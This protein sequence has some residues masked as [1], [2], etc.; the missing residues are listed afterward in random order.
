MH[1]KRSG[2]RSSSRSTSVRS[3]D[4][5]CLRN[6]R[7]VSQE[8]FCTIQPD[9]INNIILNPSQNA[10]A[11]KV[12]QE[13]FCTIPP[14]KRKK[15]SSISHRMRQKRSEEIFWK[16]FYCC[17]SYP[18]QNASFQKLA[19]TT[20]SQEIFCTL[21]I[22][23]VL[24]SSISHRMH[25]PE[26]SPRRSSTPS[27]QTKGRR[28]TTTVTECVCQKSLPGDLLHHPAK[29]KQQQKQQQSQNASAKGLSNTGC[30]DS[31]NACQTCFIIDLTDN[32]HLNRF[33]CI[34]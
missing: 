29:K 34:L 2:R 26:K 25:L 30:Q 23:K 1:S 11:R 15:L 20:V 6:A 5:V 27:R 16:Y 33:R 3:W 4:T 31:C 18:L 22:R 24:F 8:S 19:H 32:I 17:C 7:K 28:I 12:S 9:K 14:G 10:S 21:S 13:I